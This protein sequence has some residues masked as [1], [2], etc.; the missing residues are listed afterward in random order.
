MDCEQAKR[1]VAYFNEQETFV[2]LTYNNGN[3][4]KGEECKIYYSPEWVQF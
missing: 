2:R 3:G 4:I 1:F